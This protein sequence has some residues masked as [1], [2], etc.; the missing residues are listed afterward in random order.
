MPINFSGTLTQSEYLK[1]YRELVRP[2]FVRLAPLLLLFL[3]IPIITG[4]VSGGLSFINLVVP[5]GVGLALTLAL[6]YF[7]LY[8][9]RQAW[10]TLPLSVRLPVQGEISEAGLVWNTDVG[11]TK[12]KWAAFTHFVKT[13]E[14]LL[15]YQGA[16]ATLLPRAFFADDAAWN[17]AVALIQT[18]VSATPRK[19]PA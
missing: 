4:W 12:F 3:V 10:H 2:T 19:N 17:A 11:E 13:T 6:G 5:L 18:H 8:G 7:Y 16:A 14:L 1:A 15:L 9:G